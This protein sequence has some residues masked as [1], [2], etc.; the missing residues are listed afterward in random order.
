M[1]SWPHAP[2]ALLPAFPDLHPPRL[3]AMAVSSDLVLMPSISN[4]T[5]PDLLNLP[6]EIRQT[7]FNLVYAS[8]TINI[9]LERDLNGFV[10][11]LAQI[12]G[13]DSL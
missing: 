7:I 2:S 4:P 13:Y 3:K 6:F 1:L 8:A 12:T 11:G 10:G 9:V 5:K